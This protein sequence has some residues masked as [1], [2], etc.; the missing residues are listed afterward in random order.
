M[1]ARASASVARRATRARDVATPPPSWH[2]AE[3]ATPRNHI[4][5]RD[6][7]HGDIEL[8]SE[9]ARILDTPQM[10]RL[11]GIRQL[12]TAHLVF[13]C[14][15]HTRFEHSIGTLHCLARMAR[16]LNENHAADPGSLA[17][18]TPDELRILRIAA[19]VHDVTHIPNGHHIEDQ[20]GL[21]PRH[22]TEPRIRAMLGATRLGAVLEDLGVRDSVV[23]I[24][25]EGR[26]GSIPPFWHQL[27]SDTICA[28]ILDYLKRDAYF[29]GLDLHYDPRLLRYF[30]IDRASGRLFVDCEKDGMVREDIVSEILRMLEARYYF[31]ERV[32]YHH[33]KVAAGALLSRVVELAL[34]SGAASEHDLFDQ[35]DCSMI[36]FLRALDPGT[37]HVR[38]RMRRLLDMFETRTLPKRAAVLPYYLNEP[39]Q[40]R[41]VA[42]YF[43][44][45]GEQRRFAW[46]AEREDEASERFGRQVDVILYCPARE[47]QLKE[48]RTLVRFPGAGERI[49]PLNEL[50]AAI[51]RLADLEDSY[52]KLWKLYVFV[53]DPDP[54]VR[55]FIQER[56]LA[57]LPGARNALSIAGAT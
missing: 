42:E 9:E 57:A 17:Q 22:D 2:P 45:G 52:R 1:S 53:S 50:R 26:G 55:S 15:H 46:E 8:T 41:L 27:V 18:V 29:T 3:V 49:R 43:A 11:R 40:A 5:I 35:T 25:L 6:A 20:S 38:E 32:Y 23:T 16:A 37:A 10:Q 33:A 54:L 56:A 19:L 36:G 44:R 21:I 48:A 51:P 39:V 31:S 34:R 47:M 14:A 12:G 13:P 28:D 24:L 30:K 7:V 4:V